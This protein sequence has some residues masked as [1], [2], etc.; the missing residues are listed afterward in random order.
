MNEYTGE[1][2]EMFLFPWALSR[3]VYKTLCTS[4]FIP[5]AGL[6]LSEPHL[7][8][9][10]ECP[11]EESGLPHSP[12]SCLT[13]GFLGA[14]WAAS[15]Q[16]GVGFPL[17]SFMPLL[18]LPLLCASGPLSSLGFILYLVWCQDFSGINAKL[19]NLKCFL[20][21]PCLSCLPCLRQWML[22][23]KWVGGDRV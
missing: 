12:A 11:P 15:R 8:G 1:F 14:G 7:E 4:F 17:M 21:P 16:A 18:S 22:L 23:N 20:F 3:P 13:W 19:L 5:T 10:S 2:A 6:P 9:G